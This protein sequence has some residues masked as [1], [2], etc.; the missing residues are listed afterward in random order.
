VPRPTKNLK[1]REFGMLVA[2][3]LS[4]KRTK[5]RGRMWVCRCEC[6]GKRTIAAGSLLAGT[7]WHCGCRSEA[8]QL[9]AVA[10][11]KWGVTH[12][13]TNTDT[14]RRWSNL[15]QRCR[16]MVCS[17][18]RRFATYYADVGDPPEGRK[19][20]VRIDRSKKYGPGNFAW[21]SG[22]RCRPQQCA[23]AA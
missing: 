18:W 7:R 22:P 15:L 17:R 4:R 13:M 8:N 19:F 6:G 5:C 10:G 3:R 12:G 16:G 21:A 20:L 1:G 11:N 23:G 2:V 9:A 14:Y